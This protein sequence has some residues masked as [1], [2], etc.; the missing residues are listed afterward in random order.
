MKDTRNKRASKK[1]FNK[2]RSKRKY[3]GGNSTPIVYPP[4]SIKNYISHV[5]Y[6]NLDSR[7]DRK[8]KLMTTLSMFDPNQIHRISGIIDKNPNLGATKSHLM[9]LEMAAK[10]NY[11][12]VLILE[13][14]AIWANIKTSYPIF[15]GLVKNP[16]D[17]IMLGA[18]HPEY[19][20]NTYKLKFAW[21]AHAYL[22][23]QSYYKKI[24]ESF[25]NKIKEWD[26]NTS[27]NK[28]NTDI[29]PDALFPEMQ[30]TDNWFVVYPH[31]MAQ[32]V[33]R[34]NVSGGIVNYANALKSP[35]N[36]L[37]A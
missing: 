9:A 17:V 29:A 4:P 21:A 24:I 34:S 8:N 2:Q 33:T 28:K 10:N 36:K 5:I 14:D 19:N 35:E 37:K 27:T 20:K 3:R 1:R 6:I 12:N 18:F 7:V 31:L 16:Y 30:K 22:V 26:N 32:D 15:E 25:K 11:E 13:D 23:N